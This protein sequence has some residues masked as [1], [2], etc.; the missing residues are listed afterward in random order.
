MKKYSSSQIISVLGIFPS[1]DEDLRVKTFNLSIEMIKKEALLGLKCIEMLVLM[2][3]AP[4]AMI[5]RGV[6][7]GWEDQ[8]SAD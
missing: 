2:F 6:S 1:K 5:K 8:Q 7:I 3:C 4:N